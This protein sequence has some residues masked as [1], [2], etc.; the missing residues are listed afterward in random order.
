MLQ[1]CAGMCCN[2]MWFYIDMFH[3]EWAVCGYEGFSV[4]FSLLYV[5]LVWFVI[6]L[7]YIPVAAGR[8]EIKNTKSD[9]QLV[10]LSTLNYDARSTTH[11]IY[12]LVNTVT[13]KL[14]C[15][16]ARNLSS[17][18]ARDNSIF[19]LQIVHTDFVTNQYA[20]QVSSVDIAADYGLGGPGSN[21]GEDEV[22]S[23]RPD[24]PS[25]P[26]GLL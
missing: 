5:G 2:N 15:G 7:K 6:R 25:G 17:I 9:I 4:L 19:L 13:T 12:N 22:F 23:A 14:Q 26:P 24:R 20:I 8:R 1:P 16:Q 11:Q 21:P 10:F 3:C 18:P